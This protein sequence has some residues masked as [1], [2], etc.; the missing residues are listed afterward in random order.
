MIQGCISNYICKNGKI[1]D[2][3]SIITPNSKMVIYDI[4]RVQDGIPLFYEDHTSRFFKSFELANLAVPF[5]IDFFI[6]SIYSF[7]YRS[8]LSY[9]NIRCVYF[10]NETPEFLI[11]Q[12]EHSY[13]TH[14]MYEKGV[15][16]EQLHAVRENPNIKQELQIR[17]LANKVIE[18]NAVY[19]VLY[20]DTD[21]NITEGSKSNVFFIRNGEIHTALASDVLCGITSKKVL[22]L[23]QK[24][25]YPFF[26]RKISYDELS[27]FDA[28]YITGTSPKILPVSK[29]QQIKYNVSNQLLRDLMSEYDLEIENYIQHEKLTRNSK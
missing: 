24:K 4:L 27:S 1:V 2:A 15:L 5:T 28:V 22:E 17:A 14:E 25:S 11:Y 23:I 7:I 19:E 6:S 9:G 18:E 10:V 26:E 21:N 13:P 8:K 20:I 29:V 16:M 3:H 12:I